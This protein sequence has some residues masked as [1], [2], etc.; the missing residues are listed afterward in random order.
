MRRAIAATA[1]LGVGVR[2]IAIV[3]MAL[4][5]YLSA[6]PANVARSVRRSSFA[7]LVSTLNDELARGKRAK[8]SG[9]ARK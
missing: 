8:R 4:V 3:V 6:F 9:A 2:P 1:V 5:K 7:I